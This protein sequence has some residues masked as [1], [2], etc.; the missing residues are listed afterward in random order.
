MSNMSYWTWESLP[1]TM[2]RDGFQHVKPYVDVGS[3]EQK[4]G[5]LLSTE[6]AGS[7]SSHGPQT[8]P[9]ALPIVAAK[10]PNRP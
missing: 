2:S 10:T 1:A 9:L 7:V 3:P 6:A 5:T 8:R 4:T